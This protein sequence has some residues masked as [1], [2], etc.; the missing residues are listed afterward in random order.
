MLESLDGAALTAKAT[1]DGWLFRSG[2]I[3][4][5]NDI[6]AMARTDLIWSM[7]AIFVLGKLVFELLKRNQEVGTIDIHF[8]P[9]TLKAAHL[10]A[11][12][13][14]LQQLVVK[15]AKRFALERGFDKLKKLAVRRVVP[16]PKPDHRGQARDKFSMG[17]WV[18][19]RLCSNFDEINAIKE[20]SRIKSLD[21]SESVRRTAQQF[22]GKPFDES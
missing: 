1:L 20:W 5:T 13:K 21:M 14:T 16:V 9:K 15:E 4:R 18:A 10:E 22:D 19:D 17:V 6:P 12:Q 7:S 3:D 8:D 11:M 2:E